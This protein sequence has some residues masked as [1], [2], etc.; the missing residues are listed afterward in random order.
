MCT[1][2]LRNKY[3]F[4]HSLKQN[5]KQNLTQEYCSTTPNLVESIQIIT[6]HII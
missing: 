5:K 2:F 3:K 1:F 4:G 6:K